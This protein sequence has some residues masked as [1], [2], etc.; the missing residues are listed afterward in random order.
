[1]YYVGIYKSDIYCISESKY[2]IISYM[3]CLRGLGKKEYFI[4][5]VDDD[6][7]NY[8]NNDDLYIE[9]FYNEYYLPRRDIRWIEKDSEYIEKIFDDILD[10]LKYLDSIL[11][12]MK[13]TKDYPKVMDI[14]TYL[15]KLEDSKLPKIRKGIAMY[16]SI[17]F[18][19]MP[20]YIELIRSLSYIDNLDN[21]FRN[22]IT[23]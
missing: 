8:D 11:Y 1:M 9:K 17:I 21:D 22:K 16:S 7:L 12:F 18:A 19:S 10:G 2:S 3:H 13:N 6:F 14:I 23:E 4:G 15:S 5:T 20:E